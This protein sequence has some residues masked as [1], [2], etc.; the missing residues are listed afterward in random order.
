M[1]VIDFLKESGWQLE[2]NNNDISFD[3]LSEKIR[4]RTLNVPHEL[5]QLMSSLKILENTDATAWFITNNDLTQKNDESSFAWDEFEQ[6][7]LDASIDKKSKEPIIQFWESHFCFLMSVKTGYSHI[8]V[9]TKGIEKGKIVFGFEPE[10]EQVTVLANDFGEFCQI[11][12]DH[13]SDLKFNEYL[14][15]IL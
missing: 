8:S 13:I 11:V 1:G 10:Y 6:Q 3:L 14:E 2:I 7:S 12:I 9:V 4:I 15:Q 5:K